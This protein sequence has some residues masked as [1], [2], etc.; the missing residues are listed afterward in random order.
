[1]LTHAEAHL[2]LIGVPVFWEKALHLGHSTLHATRAQFQR[3]GQE[4]HLC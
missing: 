2:P 4:C 1:M 3:R